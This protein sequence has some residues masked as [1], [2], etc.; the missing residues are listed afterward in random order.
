LAG[1][2]FHRR[3]VAEFGDDA[4]RGNFAVRVAGGGDLELGAHHQRVRELALAAHHG[5]AG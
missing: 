3:R 2:R 5:L 1:G 4:M